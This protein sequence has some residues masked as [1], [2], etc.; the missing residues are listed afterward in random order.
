MPEEDNKVLKYND[1]EKSMRAENVIYFDFKCLTEEINTCH[2]NPEISSATEIN[3]HTHS[4]Y[5]LE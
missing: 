3:K 1:G 2:N 4:G 5:S